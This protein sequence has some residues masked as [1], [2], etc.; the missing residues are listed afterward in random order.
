VRGVAKFLIDVCYVGRSGRL[1]GM[2]H[3]V[4]NTISKTTEDR[5]LVLP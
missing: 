2:Q 1:Q 5:D 3:R 4:G